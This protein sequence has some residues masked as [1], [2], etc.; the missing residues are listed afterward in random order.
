MNVFGQTNIDRLEYF[1]D[2]DPGL[3]NGVSIAITPGPVQNANVT[4]NTSS[5]AVGFHTLVIRAKH[6]SGSW[7]VQDSRIV[8][9]TSESVA[10]QGTLNA[11]EYYIDSDPGHGNGTPITI[12]GAPTSVDLFP[13]IATGSL[14]AGFHVLHIRARDVDGEWGIPDSRPF[15]VVPGGINVQATITELEYFFDTEPGYG[16]G[17]PIAITSGTQINFPALINTASLSN[18]F[19]TI[20]IRAKDGDGQW[21]FAEMRT[22]YLDEFSQISAIEYYLDT[23]PGEGTATSV[24]ITPGGSIDQTFSIPTTSLANGSHTVGVRAAR[25]DGSW[26]NTTTSSFLVTEINNAPA[27]SIQP[28]TAFYVGDPVVVN[29]LIN[30]TDTEGSIASA[31]VSITSGFQNAEDEL[32][33]TS[34]NGLSGTYAQA[35][36][37]LTVSG[38][39]AVADYQTALRSVQYNNTAP[40]PNTTDRTISFAVNDGLI[41]SNAVATIVTI[42]KPPVIVAPPKDTQ[43]GGN[44]AFLVGDIFSDPDNNLDFATLTVVSAQGAFVSIAD[45]IITVFYSAVPDYNGTDQLTITICDLAGQCQVEVVLVDV[46]AEVDIYNGISANGDDMNEFFRI[47]FL[48]AK[49]KVA[50]FN[51]WGDTVFESSDYDSS[52]PLKRFNGNSTDGNPL[53]A[54]T[55]FY[56]IT[57]PAGG[58]ERSGYLH[59][60]R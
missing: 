14:S 37:V 9:V 12:P 38:T 20:S 23:D 26:G 53:T 17:T 29:S 48:P 8:Y 22:F 36:G 32:L 57:L 16:A 40:S 4:I 58:A 5:L 49:S 54:G 46:G 55:Y 39:A 18:G 6:Q 31:T 28:G 10:V 52:D 2:S 3:G 51:R 24:A 47:K 60:K 44:V 13:S 27:L 42:N 30:V 1:F 41:T 11:M 35:T 33:F 25:T 59:L 56:K 45:G 15:Y 34:Q 21:G 43:A 50:I 7:G 19:H